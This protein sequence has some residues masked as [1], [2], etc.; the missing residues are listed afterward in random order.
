M[1]RLLALCVAGLLAACGEGA[2]PQAAAGP[3][4]LLAMEPDRLWILLQAAQVNPR[5]RQYYA[6]P[7]DPR[8]VGLAVNCAMFERNALDWLHANGVTDA[9]AEHLR[10]AAFWRWYVARADAI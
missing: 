5:C 4:P 7:T 6:E 9:L 10:D 3:S 2:A 1:K 8:V